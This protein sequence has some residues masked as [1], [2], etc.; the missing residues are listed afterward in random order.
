MWNLPKREDRICASDHKDKEEQAD[1]SSDYD[2]SINLPAMS[3][4]ESHDDNG[5]DASGIDD[6]SRSFLPVDNQHKKVMQ[7]RVVHMMMC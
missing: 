4:S 7:M 1:Y 5:N 2:A 3:S 6:D